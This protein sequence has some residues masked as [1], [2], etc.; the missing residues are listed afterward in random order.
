MGKFKTGEE[1][2]QESMRRE[3]LGKTLAK[4]G[5]DILKMLAE[6]KKNKKEKE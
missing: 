3:A 4:N 6:W 2:G 1:W 5:E